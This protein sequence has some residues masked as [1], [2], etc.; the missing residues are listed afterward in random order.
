[1]RKRSDISSEA[2][3]LNSGY[4]SA[5]NNLGV[6]LASQGQ[7]G[8]AKAR[9]AD[10]M[11]LNPRYGE[12]YNCA[13]IMAAC[14]EARHRDGAGAVHFATRACELTQ[15]KS[16][17]FLNRLAAAH[18]ESKDFSAAVTC[19]MKAIKLLTD[20]RMRS[21]F[22]SRLALYQ[23]KKPYREPSPETIVRGRP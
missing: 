21:D 5:L 19:Q 3:R 18:A 16:A 22:R 13:L 8:S 7:F 2:L 14:P 17:T 9:L 10:A 15:W 1:M 20:E 4:V 23:A 11:R 12:A 6:A